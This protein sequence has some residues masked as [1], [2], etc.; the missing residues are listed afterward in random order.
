M[1][2]VGLGGVVFSAGVAS[3]FAT[4]DKAPV[5]FSVL[6]IRVPWSAAAVG[7]MGAGSLA[8]FPVDALWHSAYGLDVTLWSP[9]HLQLVGGGSFATIGLM[10]MIGEGRLSSGPTAWGRAVMILAAGASLTGMTTF[11]GEFDFGAAQFQLAY[12]P[13]LIMAAAGFTLVFCRM[14]L[15]PW[16]AVKT[17]L[18]YLTLRVL[19]GLIVHGG[20][21]HTYPRFPLYVVSALAVEAA[22][23]WVGTQSRLRFALTAG[24]LVGTVGLIGELAWVVLSGWGTSSPSL[25]PKIALLAPL[26]AVTAA[27]LG[28][29]LAKPFGQEADRI[30]LVGLALAG[31]VLLAALAVPLPRKVGDVQ[32]VIRLDQT[33]DRAKVD[34]QLDPPDAADGAVFFG[35][36]SWQGGGTV[37][38]SLKEVSPGRFVSSKSVPVTGNWKTTI[39]LLR[40]DEVMAAPIYMSADPGIE[41]G[42]SA[43]FGTIRKAEAIPA[44]PERRVSFVKNTD[45][46]LREAHPGPAWP[47]IVVWAI[48]IGLLIAWGALMALTAKKLGNPS[49]PRSTGPPS[50]IASDPTSV[51]RTWSPVA[52]A[53]S[54]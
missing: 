35:I 37:D 51:S 3:I 39:G 17:V 6:G 13:L 10:L 32:A 25:L 50:A 53:G 11:E 31:L 38:A 12:L 20:L 22:A 5:G 16:G 15:G 48:W 9:P 44:L 34:V 21:D 14:A 4:I 52:S 28:G 19:L 8:A 1:I 41:D 23:F 2:L 42:R 43:F 47:A 27:V 33:G 45:L 49:G 29:G 40:G 54:Q 36:K 26:A 30:P 46:L 7:L 18:F 24:I